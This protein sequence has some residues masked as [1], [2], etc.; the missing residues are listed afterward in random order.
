MLSVSVQCLCCFEGRAEGKQARLDQ[1][2]IVEM[3]VFRIYTSLN[4]Q[5]V[6]FGR[7]SHAL[8]CLLLSWLMS[9]AASTS[10]AA[11]DDPCMHI[12]VERRV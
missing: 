12:G 3:E 11:H 9:T 8:L 7:G 6:A 2:L 10:L 5:I 1:L 4:V